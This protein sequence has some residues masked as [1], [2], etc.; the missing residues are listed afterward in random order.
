MGSETE[1]KT[2][3]TRIIAATSLSYELSSL[4]LFEEQGCFRVIKRRF[5]AKHEGPAKAT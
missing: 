3:M 4:Y 5:A 1:R 2:I